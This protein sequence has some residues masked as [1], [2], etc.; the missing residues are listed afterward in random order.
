M[1]EYTVEE[2]VNNPAL[3]DS[4]IKQHK[5]KMLENGYT[6]EDLEILYKSMDVMVYPIVVEHFRKYYS[7]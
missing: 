7:D 4:L 6:E 2:L 3:L 1:Q 5:L